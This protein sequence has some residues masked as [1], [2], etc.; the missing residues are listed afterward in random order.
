MPGED[1]VLGSQGGNLIS[2]YLEDNTHRYS[3]AS[4]ACDVG[5]V[6]YISGSDEVAKADRDDNAK[7]PPIGVVQLKEDSTHCH[8]CHSGG[9]VF[10]S[11]WGLTTGNVYWLS[12]TPGE[13]GAQPNRPA[14]PNPLPKAFLVGTAITPDKLLVQCIPFNLYE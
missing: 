11:S 7:I 4:N 3:M 10:K 8:V 2:A 12:D 5:D 6:V 1:K 9:I 14:P 13:M